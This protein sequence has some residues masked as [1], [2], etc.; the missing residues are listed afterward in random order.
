MSEPYR[1]RVFVA[2]GDPEG[3]K[4]VELL[5]WTGVGIAFPRASWP[6]MGSRQEFN[7]SGV[8]ILIGSGE[9]T[10]DDLPTVYVGQGEEIGSRIES[11][12][13]NKEFWGWCYAFVATGN[14][15]NQAHI[16]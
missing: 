12:Y 14:A 6:R 5:N 4:I 13:V 9:G 8:Y 1:I 16:T 11:H 2:D 10:S 7:R 15:L 3:P